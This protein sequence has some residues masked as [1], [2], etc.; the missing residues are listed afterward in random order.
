M[1]VNILELTTPTN[2]REA[3]QAA[4]KKKSE[5]YCIHS[6]YQ[7]SGRQRPLSFFHNSGNQLLWSLWT[8]CQ[9]MQTCTFTLSKQLAKST[10]SNYHTCLSHVPNT[11]LIQ[12]AGTL[13]NL[14]TFH[15]LLDTSVHGFF[16]LQLV[17][18]QSCFPLK[19]SCGLGCS[20]YLYM[21]VTV[22]KLH[23][24]SS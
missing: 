24:S 4:R 18:L 16:P 15:N 23:S 14:S 9:Q 6:S 12:L 20:N 1:S 8:M 13:T 11:F 5:S 3:V 19:P 10:L 21:V 22:D 7:W 2:M 17:S